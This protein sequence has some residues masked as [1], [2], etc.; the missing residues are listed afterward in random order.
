MKTSH[1]AQPA[2]EDVDVVLRDG[3]T[4]RVRA[5]VADDREA[6]ERF[7][8][9]LSDESRLFRFF[10]PIR[11]MSR[12]AREFTDVDHRER[13]SL[14]A[15]RG[16]A[17]E[18]VGHGYYALAHP[19][20]AEVALAVADSVQGMGLGTILLGHLAAAASAAGITTFTAEVLP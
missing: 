6:L 2:L 16:D 20:T 15:L 10:S 1:R 4:V 18:I 7:L 14:L 17:A 9:G 19:G 5:A 3:S 11:D 8:A 12:A 13:H